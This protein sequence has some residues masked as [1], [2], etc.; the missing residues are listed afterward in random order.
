MCL[1]RF[2]RNACPR[3]GKSSANQLSSGT[4][5]GS[6]SY[7]P[8]PADYHRVHYTDP[9]V[10]LVYVPNWSTAPP[11]N[12]STAAAPPSTP[13]R[14]QRG[15]RQNRSPAAVSGS[16]NAPFNVQGQSARHAQESTRRT[17]GE[18]QSPAMNA[19]VR[20]RPALRNTTTSAV[21]GSRTRTGTGHTQQRIPTPAVAS[22]STR[23]A[24]G[25][26]ID[27]PIGN[28]GFPRNVRFQT[29][30]PI[31][32][33]SRSSSPRQARRRRTAPSVPRTRTALEPQS[34]HRQQCFFCC[35]CRQHRP[36]V[37]ALLSASNNSRPSHCVNCYR[38]WAGAHPQPAA[39]FSPFPMQ[40]PY[41]PAQL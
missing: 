3:P 21:A 5:R 14:S 19:G 2:F 6:S 8:T 22:P 32:S 12:W 20:L 16:H 15:T 41:T 23:T 24:A 27:T 39:A 31:S 40:S 34:S 26:H 7:L 9:R 13:S 10:P 37:D 11:N 29:A 36:L 33:S 1:S 18:P 4:R 25:V 30:S 35:V 17:R 38:S 28:R